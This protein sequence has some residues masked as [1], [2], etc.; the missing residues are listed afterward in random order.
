MGRAGRRWKWVAATG[1]ALL[2]AGA[3][4]SPEELREQH[5]QLREQLRHNPYQRAIH[6][7]SAE[8]GDILR[9]DVYAVLDHPFQSLSG[10]LKE[11]AEWCA[12]LILPFNTKYCHPIEGAAGAGL[13]LRIGRK[14]DQPVG[15][16]YRLDFSLQP[17]AARSD[18]FESRLLAETGP[19]G[20]RD[21][22]IVLAAM[23]LDANRTFMRLSYSYGS[24]GMGRMAMQVY[25]NTTGAQKVGFTVVSHDG[26]KQ[27]VYVKG[28]R[29]VI[30]RNAMRYFLAVDAH[31]AAMGAP[32]EQQLDKRL[33][34]WFNST[35]QYARQLHEMD[36]SQ[37][38]AMKRSEV[39]RQQTMLQ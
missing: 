9:G 10:A 26:N 36:R 22:R 1:L 19:I 6:I 15:D 32:P 16:A 25:L 31:L 13:M 33:M 7:E 29:G 39:A 2:A 11:P 38:V 35:E 5:A 4:A 30:E 17:V 14:A 8:T 3:A 34:T 12:I 20:T 28:M 23:P 21:Y 18:Y 24:S 37:Y 27:P